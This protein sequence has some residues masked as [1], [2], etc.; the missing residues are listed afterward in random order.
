MHLTGIKNAKLVYV[1]L[2]TPG[3][4]NYG[5]EV[6]Y[7]HMPINERFYAFDLEYDAAM[8]D[9]MQEKVN[10]CR[11]FLDEYDSKIKSLLV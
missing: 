9:K 11:L 8:I 7:S 6:I 10:N 5:N 2:D 4:A 1:L 3:E